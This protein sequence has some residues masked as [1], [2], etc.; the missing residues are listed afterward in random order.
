LDYEQ[1]SIKLATAAV[2]VAELRELSPRVASALLSLAM[3]SMSSSFKVAEDAKAVQIDVGD[4][5][6]TMQIGASLDPK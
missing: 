3:P 4:L 2:T 1:D 6:K 5:A